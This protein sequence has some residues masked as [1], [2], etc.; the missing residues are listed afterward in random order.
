MRRT[1]KALS[2]LNLLFEVSAYIQRIYRKVDF[3]ELAV[4]WLD[5]CRARLGQLWWFGL[6]TLVDIRSS[7]A[8]HCLIRRS[9]R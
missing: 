3:L 9:N 2:W 7:K 5:R 6:A 1:R 4:Q 8:P